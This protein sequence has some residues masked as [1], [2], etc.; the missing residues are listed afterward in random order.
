MH[1]LSDV[2]R[3]RR[4]LEHR[5]ERE[6]FAVPPFR[7]NHQQAMSMAFQWRLLSERCSLPMRCD[8]PSCWVTCGPLQCHSA[9][10]CLPDWLFQRKFGLAVQTGSG[11]HQAALSV[12]ALVG[13]EEGHHYVVIHSAFWRLQIYQGPL[14]E[15]T[16]IEALMPKIW[17]TAL[18]LNYGP[19]VVVVSD[20]MVETGTN[21]GHVRMCSSCSKAINLCPSENFYNSA[22]QTHRSDQTPSRKGTL[23]KVNEKVGINT[24]WGMALGAMVPVPSLSCHKWL[25]HQIACAV[26]L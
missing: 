25:I 12:L 4:M 23:R 9:L 6:Y 19:F 22:S 2:Q 11:L 8:L 10:G 17:A 18:F 3:T 16:S 26:L 20:F 15:T 24:V 1:E 7:V 13:I 5:V 14:F 21:S